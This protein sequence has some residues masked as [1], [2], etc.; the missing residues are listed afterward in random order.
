MNWS[1]LSAAELMR[2]IE[3]NIFYH[4]RSINS[5]ELQLQEPLAQILQDS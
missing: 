5:D 1:Q 2:L 4:F 3:A